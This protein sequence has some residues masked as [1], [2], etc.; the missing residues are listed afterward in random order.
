MTELVRRS[1]RQRRAISRA[2]KF[3]WEKET[4]SLRAHRALELVG[5][6]SAAQR[7]FGRRVCR[8]GCDP[9]GLPRAIS[10][11]AGSGVRMRSMRSALLGLTIRGNEVVRKNPS[12]LPECLQRSLSNL[13]F[14]FGFD[15]Q[16]ASR[17][18]C[19]V[20]RYNDKAAFETQ[21][22]RS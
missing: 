6:C 16:W 2:L 13:P 11:T 22:T 3:V 10:R 1:W 12:S 18:Q 4:H 8:R 14:Q 20:D 7:E 19:L 15:W 17:R 5:A 21:P 9:A